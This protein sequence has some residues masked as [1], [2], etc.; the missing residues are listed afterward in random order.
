L[1]SD[2]SP[3]RLSPDGK[4]LLGLKKQDEHDPWKRAIMIIDIAD[5]SETVVKL[6]E[7]TEMVWQMAWSP[8]G[9]KLIVRRE[10]L[11]PGEKLPPPPAAAA[12]AAPPVA[13]SERPKTKPEVAIRD[14]DGSNPKMT[15][16][17]VVKLG[18]LGL[19]WK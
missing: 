4:R 9:K 8:D 19:D 2:F 12:A 3:L 14:L 1:G 15:E 5:G 17:F 13:I 7:D 18:L 6:E 11:L 10:V 16:E